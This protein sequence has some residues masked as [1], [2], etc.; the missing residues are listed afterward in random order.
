MELKYIIVAQ[1]T[2]AKKATQRCSVGEMNLTPGRRRRIISRGGEEDDVQ[3]SPCG[4]GCKTSCHIKR[5]CEINKHSRD[6]LE[7][8]V[9]VTE[10]CNIATFLSKQENVES[11]LA[12]I[13]GGHTRPNLIFIL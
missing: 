6:V 4:S 11:I 13:D 9:R 12:R 1:W 8:C 7:V 2:P 3:V 10:K 5:R